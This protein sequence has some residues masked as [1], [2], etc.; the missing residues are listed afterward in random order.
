M[1]AD[2][3]QERA[4]VAQPTVER[5]VP[6]LIT[7]L[8]SDLSTLVREEVELAKTEVRVEAKKAGKAAGKLGAAAVVGLIAALLLSWALAYLIALVLPTWAGFAIVGVVYAIVAAV[9]AKGGQKQLN[10]VDPTPRQTVET[11]QE[12]KQWLK[13]R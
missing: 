5:S 3:A 9:L 4:S 2:P 1:T 11:L 13:N 12:D 8:T 10:T 7:R 6:E